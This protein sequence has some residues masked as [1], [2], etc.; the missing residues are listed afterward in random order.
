MSVLAAA[1]SLIASGCGHG[2][3]DLPP[4]S[5][6]LAVEERV[7]GSDGQNFLREITTAAWDDD[8]RRAAELFA[9]VPHD[10]RS[11]DHSA[12]SRAGRTSHAVATFLS[13]NREA[14]KSA[15]P[16]PALW[17]S[18]SRSLVPYLGAMVG[19]DGDIVDFAPL[20]G[21]NTP[22][23]HTVSLFAAITK[24]ADANRIFSEAAAARAQMYATAFANAAVAQPLMADKGV[25]QEAVLRTARLRAVAAA[26]NHLA[27]PQTE[28]P[29]SA[30]PMTDLAYEVASQTVHPGN[31][32][33]NPEFF[34]DGHLLP[35]EEISGNDLSVYDSQLA[36][37]LADVGYVND[38]LAQFSRAYSKIVNNQ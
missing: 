37:A 36:V 8:G 21:A 22:M 4:T 35:P 27:D 29:I 17:Q 7:T 3:P 5:D 13:D 38:A 16:N 1:A 2:E 26:A 15:P 10:A 18:F 14:L 31:P 30:R 25:A 33:V 32:H 6:A 23:S 34:R 9:W 11:T 24:D 12:A 19:D 20:D 28:T